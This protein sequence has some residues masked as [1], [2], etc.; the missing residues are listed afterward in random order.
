MGHHQAAALDCD[1]KRVILEERL[2]SFQL[3][4]LTTNF[5]LA[6]SLRTRLHSSVLRMSA[7]RVPRPWSP[8]NAT[9]IALHPRQWKVYRSC[10]PPNRRVL[11]TNF[12]GRAQPRQRGA[13]GGLGS[14]LLAHS[15]LTAAAAGFL[16]LIQQPA[17]PAWYC[18]PRRFDTMPSQPSAQACL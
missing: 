1:L 11:R 10:S 17:R 13:L 5:P 9:E 4:D 16:T 3:L 12:I 18:E 6:P 15:R 7:T 8:E 14:D 2:F